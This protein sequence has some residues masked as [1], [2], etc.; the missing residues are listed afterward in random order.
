MGRVT[1][2]SAVVE[3]ITR[4][5]NADLPY[6]CCGLLL[7]TSS[8]ID[9]AVPAR[10]AAASRT[11]FL[12]DPGDHFAAIREARSSAQEVVGVYHSHPSSPAVPSATDV[13]EANDARLIHLIVSLAPEPQP[14]IRAF[15]F[16]GGNFQPLELVSVG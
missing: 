6:E 8:H 13:A 12:I 7:G 1:I 5:A 2:R 9:R 15:R 10:N 3:Q 14:V 11:R 4:H 16:T